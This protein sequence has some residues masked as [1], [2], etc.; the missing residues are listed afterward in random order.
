MMAVEIRIV[1]N[2]EG[3]DRNFI[4]ESGEIKKEGIPQSSQSASIGFPKADPNDTTEDFEINLGITKDLDLTW[5]L[6]NQTT[7]RA[8]GTYT[9][10]VKTYAEMLNYLEDVIGFPG[11][12][13]VTYTITIIDKFRTRVAVYSL[14]SF[15]ID[16]DQAL[17]PTGTLKFNWKRQIS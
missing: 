16:T 14:E 4:F 15:N 8:E 5:I 12:G 11:I 2:K 1:K 3:T 6:Y 17:H 10:T 7:D 13:I 9:S